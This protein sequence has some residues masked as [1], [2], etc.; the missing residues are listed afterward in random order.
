[1]NP[2]LQ[3]LNFCP[4]LAALYSRDRVRSTSGKEFTLTACSTVNNLVILKNLFP[5]VNPKR[6][7]EIGMAFGG[8]CLMFAA[9][10]R[11]SGQAPSAQHVAIDPFQTNHW[12]RIGIQAVE[13]AGLSGYVQVREELSSLALPASV[14]R[15]EE[16]DLIYIDGSHLFED[17]FIDAYYSFRLVSKNGIVLFDDCQNVHVK[18]AIR[19]IRCNMGELFEEIDIGPLRDDCGRALKYRIAR[20][21]GH[22]QTVGFRRTGASER[23]WDSPLKGF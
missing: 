9:M 6:S 23:C 5:R 15:K 17:V 22:V 4:E 21:L 18:K 3:T 12:E 1:M 8:S 13:R 16:F 2:S 14:A 20:L 19:F 10:Y 11:Q 7:L